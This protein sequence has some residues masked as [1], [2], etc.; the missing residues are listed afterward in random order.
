MKY[1]KYFYLKMTIYIS[2]V[3]RP[4]T[5]MLCVNNKYRVY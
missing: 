3:S 5:I 1:I 2:K 4:F